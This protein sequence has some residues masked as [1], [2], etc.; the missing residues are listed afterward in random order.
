[1]NTRG[2]S[3]GNEV[4][5]AYIAGFIDADGCICLSSHKRKSRNGE[6]R[7]IYLPSISASQT[8]S[9]TADYLQENLLKM[10][11][12]VYRQAQLVNKA[13]WTDRILL[14]INGMKRC[15]PVLEA[16][17]PYLVT[18]KREAELLLDFINHRSVLCSRDPYGAKEAR[19]KYEM[20][21]IKKHRNNGSDRAHK[22]L[23][24]EL[25][26]TPVRA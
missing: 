4:V 8:C 11:F 6:Q 15:K 23:L 9:L 12:A 17:I 20:G 21:F 10:G 14:E 18:K 16:L 26:Q 25:E 19:I 3:A 7:I 2:Q 22:R 13:N 24:N 5:L 1:M